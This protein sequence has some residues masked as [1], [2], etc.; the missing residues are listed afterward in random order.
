MKKL[1]PVVILAFV[2]CSIVS[3]KKNEFKGLKYDGTMAMDSKDSWLQTDVKN[4]DGKRVLWFQVFDQVN[5]EKTIESYKNSTDKVEKYPANINKDKWIWM[6]VNN[7]IEIRLLADDGSK[8]FQNTDK[9][10]KF[11]LSFDLK[12]LEAIKGDKVTAKELQ[13]YI[14]KFE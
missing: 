11:I 7:R 9:L 5:E 2:V 6:M 14:P 1:I 13:K 3:C 8:D 4:K 10:K 12:G